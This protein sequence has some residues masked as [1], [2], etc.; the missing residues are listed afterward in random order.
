MRKRIQDNDNEDDP[1]FQGKKK[2]GEGKRNVHQTPRRTKE[3]RDT[4]YTRKNQYQNNIDRIMDNYVT[5]RTEWWKSI[6]Q[7]SI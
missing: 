7:N 3:Q 6:P 1:G 2:V 4:Q 5:W